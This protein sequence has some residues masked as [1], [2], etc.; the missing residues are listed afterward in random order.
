MR[1]TLGNPDDTE[2]P[3]KPDSRGIERELVDRATVREEEVSEEMLRKIAEAART[4]ELVN[5]LNDRLN[6]PD[7]TVLADTQLADFFAALSRER[8]DLE[9]S[10]NQEA[11]D[12]LAGFLKDFRGSLFLHGGLSLQDALTVL[13]LHWTELTAVIEKE[14]GHKL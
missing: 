13:S 5:F 12:V 3:H 10:G 8:E 11:A 1:E 7:E 9:R 6:D 4:R 2:S 14:L